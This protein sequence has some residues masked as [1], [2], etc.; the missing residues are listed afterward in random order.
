V[1]SK[2]LQPVLIDLE[3]RIRADALKAHEVI[4]NGFEGL[5]PL[6]ARGLEGQ[7]W[8]RICEQGFEDVCA[9][10]GGRLLEGGLIPRTDLKIHQ[11][12][13]RFEYEGQGVILALASM[14]VTRSLPAKNK[15][16]LA[17]VS[18]NYDLSLRLDFDG[19]G[20][21]PGDI[22]AVLLIARDRQRAGKIEEL[23]VGVIESNYE[24]YPA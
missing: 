11:P 9:M 12:F 4:R 2:W 6:R 14:P 20:P 18:I 19:L 5:T 3:D 10:H 15:S 24:S 7:A 17:G 21:K 16:R 23:A 8:F 13:M 22:F 1:L